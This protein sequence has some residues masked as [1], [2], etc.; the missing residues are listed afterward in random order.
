MNILFCGD[1][2]GKSGRQS[3][4]THLP[5]L[6]K[7]YPLDLIIVNGEN[8]AHGFGL[9]ETI[10]QEFYGYGVDVITTGNH[11]WD[12]KDFVQTLEKDTNVLRPLNY[13]HTA[14]GKGYGIY[15]TKSGAKILVVSSLHPAPHSSFC[16][17]GLRIG[18]K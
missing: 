9:N 3:L 13:P 12:Q 6:Q 4:K 16:T 18:R 2:V 15:Q 7:K 11:V 10:C 8:A 17:F 14:P 1:V 5:T